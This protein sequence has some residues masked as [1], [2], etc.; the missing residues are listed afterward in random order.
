VGELM[1]DKINRYALLFDFYGG[2]LTDRQQEFFELYYHQDWSLGEIAD[3]FQISRPAVH[4]LIKRAEKQLD[5]YEEKLKLIEKFVKI[6][7]DL[8]RLTE[9]MEKLFL[10]TG[11]K[12]L[13]NIRIKIE[14]IIKLVRE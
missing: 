1:L 5:N 11:C 3:Y 6:D 12:E 4:D 8:F 2:L 9:D 14:Q 13:L 7:A 10:D